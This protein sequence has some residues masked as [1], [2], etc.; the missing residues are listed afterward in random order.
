MGHIKDPLAKKKVIEGDFFLDE[1]CSIWVEYKGL[2]INLYGKENY[3]HIGAYISGR[4]CEDPIDVLE[5][6]LKQGA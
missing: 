6:D 3:L 4:E 2:V 5:L 1:N